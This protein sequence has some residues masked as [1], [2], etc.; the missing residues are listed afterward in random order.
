MCATKSKGK[1]ITGG[2]IELAQETLAQF[3]REVGKA[4]TQLRSLIL[5]IHAR[6]K[7]VGELSEVLRWGQL[8]YL[9][10]KPQ[11]GSMIR[12]GMSQSG[13]PAMFFHCG[14]SLI[15]TFRAQ[16]SHEFEFE[17]NR[18]VVL[19]SSVNSTKVALAHCIEQALTY[20]LYK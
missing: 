14:T 8:S 17:G 3:P 16:Y 6:T 10:V 18:A 19:T 4:L 11:T 1:A 9:T 15:E 12:L 2:D 20:K 7:N 5:A 13:K